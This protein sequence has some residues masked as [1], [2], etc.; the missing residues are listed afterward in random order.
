VSPATFGQQD[1]QVFFNEFPAFLLSSADFSLQ[2]EVVNNSAVEVHQLNLELTLGDGMTYLGTTGA[3]CSASGLL[4]TCAVDSLPASG[5]LE[6]SFNLHIEP[7][8]KDALPRQ[9]SFS[10][11][12]LEPD[13]QPANNTTYRDIVVQR[14]FTYFNDF[15]SGAG[16]NWSQQQ[17]TTGAAGLTTLGP[18]ANDNVRLSFD[19]LPPHD[20]AMI[21]YDLYVLGA[22]DGNQTVQDSTPEV[23]GPDLWS[24]YMDESPLLVTTFSNQAQ[25]AQAY[26]AGY[27]RG[28]N[29]AQTAVAEVGHFGGPVGS[30][31][32]RYHICFWQ[33]HSGKQLMFTFYG[34][35]LDKDEGETWALDNVSVRVSNHAADSHFYVPQVLK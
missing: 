16:Q 32:A 26:P 20:R 10:A 31:D 33:E 8:V 7:V 15:S 21:C 1:V 35:N 29:P 25:F 13:F 3:A 17:V 30:T 5:H 34:V 18:F 14:A 11:H 27:R 22:W 19:N 4:V 6:L 24:N 2:A 12:A 9:V 23:I 28:E